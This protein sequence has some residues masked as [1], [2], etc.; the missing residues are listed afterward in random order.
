MAEAAR[1]FTPAQENVSLP[2]H[3][4]SL[5]GQVATAHAMPRLL[6]QLLSESLIKL[7]LTL[8]Q[9]SLSCTPPPFFLPLSHTRDARRVAPGRDRSNT[10]LFSAWN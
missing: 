6:E 3:G 4:V 8:L 10:C 7:P 2:V 1:Y 5:D 9:S